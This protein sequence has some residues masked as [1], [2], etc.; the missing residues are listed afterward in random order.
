M[1]IIGKL[2]ATN[3]IWLVPVNMRRDKNAHA[4]GETEKYFK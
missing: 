2:E 3:V 1:S 4:N